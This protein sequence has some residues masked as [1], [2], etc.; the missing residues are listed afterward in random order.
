MAKFQ[1]LNPVLRVIGQ[2]YG[3]DGKPVGAVNPNVQ[4][5]G[6]KYVYS[7]LINLDCPWEGTQVYTSFQAN[8]VALFE[9]LLSIQH[10]GLAQADQPIPEMFQTIEGCYVS[11]KS[12]QPFYKRHLSPH[13]ANPA[14]G[15]PAIQAGEIVKQGGV[16]VIFTELVVFCQYYYDSR[17]EKQWMKGCTPEDVGRRAFQNYCIPAT[18]TRA[19][20]AENQAQQQPTETVGGQ[21]INTV[22]PQQAQQ[23]Q[24][25]QNAPQFTQGPAQQPGGPLP[26]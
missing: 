2:K 18:D 15:T 20:A 6:N 7:Q 22:N 9:P 25:Q 5:S 12:P 19:L 16:P 21:Q 23:P 11:W 26:Y 17:G 1:L 4:N 13:P 14:K 3:Q 8:V 24:Q 10:G